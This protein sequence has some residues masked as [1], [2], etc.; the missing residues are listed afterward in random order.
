VALGGGGGADLG[1]CRGP[2]RPAPRA[3][4]NPCYLGFCCPSDLCCSSLICLAFRV[5]FP[6]ANFFNHI[7]LAVVI[8]SFG[9]KLMQNFGIQD[10]FDL[11]VA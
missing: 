8:E 4:I 6:A 1:I 3:G 10:S 9:K 7:Y 11:K 2:V 5:S